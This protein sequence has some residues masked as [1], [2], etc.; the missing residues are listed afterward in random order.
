MRVDIP[1]SND[2]IEFF[3]GVNIGKVRIISFL[4]PDHL[5]GGF[6]PKRVRVG[7]RKSASTFIATSFTTPRVN[8]SATSL[9]G[10]WTRLGEFFL[11]AQIFD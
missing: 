9:S 10:I 4:I 11:K 5:F 7:K 3:V 8:A 1:P 6:A 2:D